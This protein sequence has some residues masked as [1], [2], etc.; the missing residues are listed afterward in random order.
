VASLPRA[1]P[2]IRKPGFAQPVI[3]QAAVARPL[4]PT[5]AFRRAALLRGATAGVRLA[6][7]PAKPPVA[8]SLKSAS[9]APCAPPGKGFAALEIPE[10]DGVLRTGRFP[11]DSYQIASLGP[12][13][14]SDIVSEALPRTTVTDE[15]IQ[16]ATSGCVTSGPLTI[17]S[18]DRKSGLTGTESAYRH[19]KD[20]GREVGAI[21]AVHYVRMARMFAKNPPS[22]A[23]VKTR[24]SNGDKIIFD[25][26]TD[27]FAV[28]KSNGQLRTFFVPDP[29]KHGHKSNLDYFNAQQ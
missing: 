26:S 20:H 7:Y 16:V 13:V 18:P 5:P 22:S 1:A 28:I 2:L 25:P 9:A 11:P 15:R 4:Q 3:Q 24:K 14:M 6:A 27:R 10:P 23:L 29:T 21:N 19:Y 8:T 17:W 12:H